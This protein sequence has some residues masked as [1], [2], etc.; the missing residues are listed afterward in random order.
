MGGRR[1]PSSDCDRIVEAFQ[2]T[3][4]MIEECLERW[5]AD[6]ITVQIL[7]AGR[8]GHHARVGDLAPHGARGAPRRRDLDH[9]RD[10]RVARPRS[11]RR[12]LGASSGS[13]LG[14][15]GS[16]RPRDEWRE[17][18]EV[19]LACHQARGHHEGRVLASGEGR[20]RVRA[21]GPSCAR[22][23]RNLSPSTTRPAGR[24]G[25]RHTPALRHTRSSRLPTTL[26]G[27]TQGTHET[28]PGVRTMHTAQTARRM[29]SRR[30]TARRWSENADPRT[31]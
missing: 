7:S 8:T 16:E 13:R 20:R 4:G 19:L 23:P 31:E 5:T 2:L 14:E 28:I 22:P 25:R 26:K 27:C 18:R 17:R 11:L 21:S 6:D 3:W 15:R 12:M 1:D 29:S 9:S 24:R 10:Q 30:S